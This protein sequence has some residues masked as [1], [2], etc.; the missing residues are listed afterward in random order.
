MLKVGGVQEYGF[1][2]RW[3]LGALKA[4]ETSHYP[5][6]TQ[7]GDVNVL[8]IEIIGAREVKLSAV[9]CAETSQ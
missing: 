4:V 6:Q 9:M 7:Q 5:Q 1:V 2:E 8:W 3:I